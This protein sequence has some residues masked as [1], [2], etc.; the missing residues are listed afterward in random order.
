[1]SG[2]FFFL[3]KTSKERSVNY[4][5]SL[6]YILFPNA[7]N[8][9]YFLLIFLYPIIFLHCYHPFSSSKVTEVYEGINI[10]M[11]DF[12]SSEQGSEEK[13]IL[14]TPVSVICLQ[15]GRKRDLPPNP[16]FLRQMSYDDTKNF[17]EVTLTI[18]STTGGRR[19]PHSQELKANKQFQKKGYLFLQTHA[20]IRRVSRKLLCMQTSLV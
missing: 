5:S 11:K 1:M 8:F 3:L 4:L 6:L 13:P 16:C 15:R 19:Q 9:L 2:F 20:S 18:I 14:A 17:K 7:N 12:S 10:Q